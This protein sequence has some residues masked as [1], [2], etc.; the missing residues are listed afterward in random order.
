[1]NRLAK[2]REGRK[3][4]DW[5][6]WSELDRLIRR[7]HGREPTPEKLA[8]QWAAQESGSKSGVSGIPLAKGEGRGQFQ[9][10]FRMILNKRARVAPLHLLLEV[11]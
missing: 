10:Q 3:L 1:L 9:L 5:Q 8:P 2:E 4:E 11:V 7:V 6:S